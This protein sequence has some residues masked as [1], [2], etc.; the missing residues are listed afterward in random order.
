MTYPQGHVCTLGTRLTSGNNSSF[1]DHEIRSLGTNAS[2]QKLQV[3][4][5]GTDGRLRDPPVYFTIFVFFLPIR[6]YFS[7]MLSYFVC[8]MGQNNDKYSLHMG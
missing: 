4:I 8:N 6:G 7:I 2:S 5:L 3:C 1:D